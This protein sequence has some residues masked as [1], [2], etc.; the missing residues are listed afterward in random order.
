M[1]TAFDEDLYDRAQQ[2]TASERQAI[3]DGIRD[4]LAFDQLTKSAFAEVTAELKRALKLHPHWPD[5]AIHAAAIVSEESGELT[6]ACNQA[7]YEPGKQTLADAHI[8]AVQTAA[9][10]IRFLLNV[11]KNEGA[12]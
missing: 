7:H 6:R 12:A 10:A 8:E 5:D 2:F 4:A 3:A 1:S 11:Y 9:M